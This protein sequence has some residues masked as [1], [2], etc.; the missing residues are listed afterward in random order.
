MEFMPGRDLSVGSNDNGHTS[1]GEDFWIAQSEEYGVNIGDTTTSRATVGVQSK[2]QVA[3][4]QSEPVHTARVKVDMSRIDRLLTVDSLFDVEDLGTEVFKMLDRFI[5]AV[6]QFEEEYS[7]ACNE[8]ERDIA[9]A[10]ADAKRQRDRIEQEHTAILDGIKREAD[11]AIENLNIQLREAKTERQRK[12]QTATNELKRFRSTS[13]E[14][15]TRLHVANEAQSDKIKDGLLSEVMGYY[16]AVRELVNKRIASDM[17]RTQEEVSR[18]KLSDEQKQ[19]FLSD[20]CKEEA[21]SLYDAIYVECQKIIRRRLP[22]LCDQL[23]V[24]CGRAKRA[25]RMLLSEQK[26][27]EEAAKANYEAEVAKRE[28]ALEQLKKL[29]RSEDERQQRDVDSQTSQI[30]NSSNARASEEN[31][32]YQNTKSQT[33]AT[34]RTQ[35]TNRANRWFE[36]LANRKTSFYQKMEVVFPVARMRELYDKLEMLVEYT[37]EPFNLSGEPKHSIAIGRAKVGFVDSARMNSEAY[38]IIQEWVKNNYQF[39]QDDPKSLRQI[40]IPY[41]VSVDQ[42]IAMLIKYNDRFEEKIKD[43]V[44]GIGLRMIWAI[45]ASLQEFCLLDTAAIGSY[46]TLQS[47]DPAQNPAA[48]GE[49]VKSMI[50]GGKVFQKKDEMAKQIDEVRTHFEDRKGSMGSYKTLRDFNSSNFMSREAYQ[51]VIVQHF[52]TN[53]ENDSIMDITTMARDCRAAGFSTILTMPETNE[54]Y[55][56]DQIKLRVRDLETYVLVFQMQGDGSF[57]IASACSTNAARTAIVS[58][59]GIP[60]PT[61][62]TE[63]KSDFF[64]ASM[65]ALKVAVDFNSVAPVQNTRFSESSSQGL[66]IPLGLMRGGTKF[67]LRMDDIHIHTILSGVTGSGKTNLLHVLLLNIMLQY[68][69]DEAEIYL[70]DFKH[71]VDFGIYSNYNLPNFRVLSITSEVEFPL[72]ALEEIEAEFDRRAYTLEGYQSIS[73]YNKVQPYDMRLKRIVLILDELYVL[74]RSAVSDGN[75]K[76]ADRIMQIID[77]I[78]HESRAFGI[79][80]LIS[81]QDIS[82]VNGIGNIVS[83][84]A[85]R[86]AMYTSIQDTQLLLQGTEA[87]ALANEITPSSQGTCVYSF[88]YGKTGKM[89][90]TAKNEPTSQAKVLEQI[91]E[92]YTDRK[93]QANVRIL[94]TEPSKSKYHPF[95]RFVDEGVLPEKERLFIGEPLTLLKEFNYFPDRNL[96]IIGGDSAQGEIAGFGVMFS[97]LLSLLLIKLKMRKHG[98]DLEILCADGTDDGTGNIDRND[99]FWQFCDSLM[100]QGDL[101]Q[102]VAGNDLSQHIR[103]L[104]ETIKSRKD[105]EETNHPIWFLISMVEECYGVPD[106]DKMALRKILDDGPKKGIHT[107]LWTKDAE[108]AKRF[109]LSDAPCDKLILETDDLDGFGVRIKQN[110]AAG[111]KAQMLGAR[112]GARLRLYDLPVQPWVERI[113]QRIDRL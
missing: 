50:I 69:P 40:V 56:D 27:E 113:L 73:E 23:S 47:M 89:S 8:R 64:N 111:Y 3:S 97:S 30:K 104:T 90:Y 13:E 5:S 20:Q 4:T 10:D 87:L 48:A 53:F 11:R 21:K 26:R 79:H 83:Q 1:F 82:Q 67:E 44:N 35:E 7:G 12:L 59:F 34:L 66:V 42:G 19:H 52:P 65:G 70:I 17:E 39:M 36:D 72:A 63:M 61:R 28:E 88:D 75:Q 106:Q 41:I 24:V 38:K 43:Y 46:A 58:L 98:E 57:K 107:I 96:W 62:L 76:Y 110:I 86:I 92:H 112:G 99:R 37:N 55:M 100:D 105:G 68:A 15:L 14:E 51:A 84:C 74:M 85:N 91:S 102:Y 60:S 16:D 22:E 32:R 49:L 81:G 45:P 78:A 109:H 94:L 25:Y 18:K 93:E 31:T 95:R 6:N 33:N 101:I 108:F 77:K 9:E 54:N 80:M 103:R 71:G 29:N 2:P